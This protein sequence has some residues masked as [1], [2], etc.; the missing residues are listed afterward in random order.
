MFLREIFSETT[1]TTSSTS[2]STT[3]SSSTTAPPV[4]PLVTHLAKAAEFFRGQ[5]RGS[6]ARAHFGYVNWWKL[7]VLHYMRNHPKPRYCTRDFSRHLAAQ[8]ISVDSKDIR[9]FCQKHGIVRDT[10]PGRPLR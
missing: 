9:R 1:T 4:P 7:S 10:R 5:P 8:K 2:T 6:I 3:T